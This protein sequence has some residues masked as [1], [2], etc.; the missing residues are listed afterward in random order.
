M[1]L[2][3]IAGMAALGALSKGVGMIGAS[4]DRK[5]AMKQ[6]R[7]LQATARPTYSFDPTLSQIGRTSLMDAYNPSGFGQG[8]INAFNQNINR[9]MNTQMARGTSLAGGSQARALNAV[10][11]ANQ[12]NAYNTL[13]M[14]D[15][16]LRRNSKSTNLNRAMQVAN[17]RQGIS[18]MQTNQD[19]NY[20]NQLEQGYGTAAR[21]SKDY[22]RGTLSGLGD[23][24]KSGATMLGMYGDGG[25][26][27]DFSR[28]NSFGSRRKPSFQS[29]LDRVK[30]TPFAS[31]YDVELPK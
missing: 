18:N 11:G 3:L 2:P 7:A 13:A 21:M 4:R 14:N 20:R 30:Y 15:A 19:L 16:T 22:M 26:D 25:G 5:Q 8:E 28:L 17:A 23:D 31:D 27:F 6:L 24:M 9:G 10:M 12:M 29:T 1:A